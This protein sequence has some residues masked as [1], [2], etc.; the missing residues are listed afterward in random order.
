MDC[1]NSEIRFSRPGKV[2]EF[3][4]WYSRGNS[5]VDRSMF[6]SPCP[7]YM[8]IVL[9]TWDSDLVSAKLRLFCD[10]LPRHVW[11]RC[12]DELRCPKCIKR[13]SDWRSLRKHMNYFCQMEP[14]F[15]CPYCSHRA[16][17]P[18][19]LKYHM[20]REHRMTLDETRWF[21]LKL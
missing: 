5:T 11:R 9:L 4:R 7:A 3:N 16:R 19:L 8:F 14:L 18:T 13:Y 12:K 17:I 6:S 10:G 1:W 20:V 15:P 2:N 21:P